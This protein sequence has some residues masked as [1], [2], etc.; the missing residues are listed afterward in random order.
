[1]MN[2]QHNA[3]IVSCSWENIAIIAKRIIITSTNPL[4]LE[5]TYLPIMVKS[6]KNEDIDLQNVLFI[7]S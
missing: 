2:K 7:I 1:M 5:N 3:F 6:Y 4:L